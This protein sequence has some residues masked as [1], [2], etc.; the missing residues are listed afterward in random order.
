[1]NG[2]DILLIVLVA[3]SVVA[4]FVRGLLRELIALLTWLI[5]F[6]LA[7]SY[8]EQLEPYLGGVLAQAGL[9]LWVART[10]I[11]VAVLIAGTLIGSIVAMFVRLSLFSPLDRS[12]G[13]LFG[14]LRSIVAVGLLI[15]AGHALR[16]DQESWWRGSM[17]VPYAEGP[18]NMLRALVGER[19]I[20]S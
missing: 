5:G 13:G 3:V 7:W 11:F 16:M 10:L 2:I 6:L 18:A 9:R 20:E 14:L 19:K 15:I 12:L 4:G 8:A 1:M 17:L